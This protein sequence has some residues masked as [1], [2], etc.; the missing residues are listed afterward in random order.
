MEF[1]LDNICNLECIMC[2]G[3]YSS[4]I[5]QNIEKGEKY[6]S[7]YDD[8]F[9]EQLAPFIPFLEQ[10]VFTGGEPFLFP[11]YYKIWDLIGKLKPELQIYI[12]TN[13]TVLNDKVKH[14]LSKLNFNFTI[15]IDSINENT[16][17]KIR[18]NA[19]LHETLNNIDYFIKYC[20]E[21]NSS[22]NIK[23]LVIPQN[24]K[25]IPSLFE[26]FNKLQINVLP[27]LVYLPLYT[28]MSSLK[29]D[30]LNN[31]IKDLSSTSFSCDSAITVQNR[32]RLLEIIRQIELITI[33]N[34]YDSTKLKTL[35][36]EEL[37]QM[38]EFHILEGFKNI[39]KSALKDFSYY[40]N[41][42][43]ILYASINQEFQ[44]K[45]AMINFLKLSPEFLINEFHRNNTEKLIARF[46]QINISDK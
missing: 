24:Y 6:V 45:T 34:N 3:E 26:Y 20:N 32:N 19:K 37:K 11:I 40:Q 41:L 1:Q 7:P 29:N 28:S 9:V 5:R 38:L 18:R 21:R 25:D 44:L 23:C 13:G 39:G 10:A 33:R 17:N 31:V 2:S 14:Y 43:N 30:D 12:S 8:K 4:K 15:S 36:L 35:N 22:L 46:R 27:K 42:L 16:Y